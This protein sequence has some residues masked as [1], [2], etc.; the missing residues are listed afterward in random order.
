MVQEVKLMSRLNRRDRMTSSV[1][2]PGCL[3][4]FVSVAMVGTA[5]ANQDIAD[6]S[7]CSCNTRSVFQAPRMCPVG[8][9]TASHASL[10][11]IPS[12]LHLPS[13]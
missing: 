12:L 11:Q 3:G 2:V 6:I 4:I 13:P 7:S 1:H 9:E 8:A 5:A 10:T